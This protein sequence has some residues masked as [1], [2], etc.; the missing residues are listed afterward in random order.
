MPA[1]ECDIDHIQPFA[2]GGPTTRANGRPA[3]SFHNRHRR[4]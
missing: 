3:C 2:A 1:H 4:T